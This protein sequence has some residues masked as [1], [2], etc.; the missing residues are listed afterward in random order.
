[1]SGTRATTLER[2][3]A[4]APDVGRF[5][6]AE[7]D[8]CDEPVQRYFRSAVAPGTAL[9]RAARIRMRGLIRIGSLWVP[10]RAGE[11]LAPLHGYFWPATVAA[12]LLKGSDWYTDGEASMAWKLL[13][14]ISVIRT[15]GP[16]I[17][18]SALGRTAAEGIWLPTALLPRYGVQWHADDDHHVVARMPISDAELTLRITI[19]ERGL[20]R[21]D[22]LDRWG[23]PDSTGQAGEH[24]FGIDV[25]HSRTFACGLTVPAEGTGGWF[26]STPRWDEG[27][28]FRYAIQDLAPVLP[29]PDP[30]WPDGQHG[31]AEESNPC[32]GLV[33][34]HMGVLPTPFA[35]ADA[36]PHRSAGG[37]RS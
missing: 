11:L 1:M 4:D 12:G 32:R 25:A 31:C 19:D 36:K 30:H 24:P 15:T 5:S 26:H 33:R 21:S 34:T 2:R 20:V 9:A 18:R 16:D 10:F 23:D 14:L 13:G 7:I 27:A 3:L 22:H 35:R 6:E 17:A 29:G 8:G 37:E 28:F